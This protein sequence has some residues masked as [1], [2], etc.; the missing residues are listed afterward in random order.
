MD[1]SAKMWRFG[2][3]HFNTLDLGEHPVSIT[4]NDSLGT[5]KTL[6]GGNK[7]YDYYSINA[8]Q[9]AGIGEVSR[10]PYS[11]KVVL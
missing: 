9:D 10:L 6:E 2:P 1:K 3:S 11:L 7:S 5:R 4:G 8:A